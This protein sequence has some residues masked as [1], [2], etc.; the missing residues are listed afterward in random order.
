MDFNL[1]VEQQM[2]RE[3]FADFAAREIASQ[4]ER[5]DR[6][7][8]I[9][10][11]LLQ[12]IAGQGFLAAL[13]PEDMDG[14]GLDTI[15][16]CLLLEEMSRADF[17]VA[18]LIGI[19][20][21]LGIKPLLD[22][23]SGAQREAYLEGMA[24]G[25]LIGAFALTEPSAGSDMA[26]LTTRATLAGDY[27]L[28]NGSKIWVSN[29]DVAGLFLIFAR[30]ER[31]VT[32]FLVERDTPGLKVGYREKT[33]GL[34]GLAC[35]TLYLDDCPVPAANVLGEVGQGLHIARQAAEFDRLGLSAICL[36][37]A[38]HALAAGIRF[39][40]EHEQFG[41]PIAR[42]Q[43]IQNFVA[44]AATEIEAFR[45]LVY[46]TAWLAE[47]GEPFGYRS[48]MAK[49]FG[50]QVAMRTADNMLQ[51]HGGY[52]YMKEYAIERLYRDCRALA[53]VCGTSQIQRFLIARHVYQGANLQLTIHD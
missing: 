30:T 23:G 45:D 6:E 20:N 17:S 47:E 42:K 31:G 49:L 1:T 16:Y 41:G 39:S 38:E 13:I 15:S 37:G 12:K 19:H 52:G 50:A 53:I 29:G 44:D 25:E 46:H 2:F 7:E 28:L 5:I 48:S 10:Q 51:L 32:A 24:Y 36:G 14:V 27:Y 3:M 22:F 34:R 4:A 9:P 35:R 43:A 26:A 18:M 33:L 21:G 8:A 40:I 11:A